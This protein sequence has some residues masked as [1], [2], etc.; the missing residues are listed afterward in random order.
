[1]D[2]ELLS[3]RLDEFKKEILQMHSDCFSMEKAFYY[4]DKYSS[5]SFHIFGLRELE[6]KAIS[7]LQQ[8]MPEYALNGYLETI[9]K[10]TKSRT[11]CL[12]I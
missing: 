11:F 5:R 10:I 8:I 1:M 7:I 6:G 4:V 12:A 3:L 9:Y 2:D